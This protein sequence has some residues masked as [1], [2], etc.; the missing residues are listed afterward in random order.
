MFTSLGTQPWAERSEHMKEQVGL[1][2]GP[3]ESQFPAC[4][5][6]LA[7]SLALTRIDHCSVV[8]TIEE[9]GL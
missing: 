4:T 3:A 1:A 8:G 2:G 9:V 6:A 7:S 5:P